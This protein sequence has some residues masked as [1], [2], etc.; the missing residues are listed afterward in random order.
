MLEIASRLGPYEVIAPLGAGGMG[1]VYRARDTRLGREVAIKVLPAPFAND[2]ERRARFEREAKAVAAL[3]HPNILAIHDYGSHEGITFAVMELLEGETLR[4]RLD[5]GALS[6]REGAE[7]GAAIA[8]GLAAAHAKGIVH[9]DLKPDNLF[10]TA[11]HRVKILDFGLARIGSP[12]EPQS[13][14]S[15]Y[16]PGETDPGR[17]M[18][19]VGYMSPEQVR[20]QPV[21]ARSDVFAM[22]CVLYE[23]LSGRRPFARETPAETQTAILREEPVP[24]ASTGASVPVEL[25][26]VVC[27]CLEKNVAVRCQAARDLAFALRAVVS[28][29]ASGLAIPAPPAKETS[30]GARKAIDSLAILPLVNAGADASLDYLSDGITESIIQILS[31]LPKLRVMARSTV[32]RYKGR[33]VDAQTVGQTLNVRAVFTGRMF[34]RGSRLII[35]VELVDVADGSQLWGEQYSREITEILALEEAIAQE[36]AGTLRLRLSREQKKQLRKRSTGNSEAYQ[37]Y[38][39]GRYHWNKRNEEGIRR[40]IAHFDLAVGLDSGFSQAHAGLADCYALLPNYASEAPKLALPRAEAAARRALEL[41]DSLAEAHVSLG[42][43]KYSFH[44]DW[45]GAETHFQRGIELN[46]NYATAHHWYAYLLMLLGRFEEALPRLAKA[47]QVDPLSLII[48]ATKAYILYFARRYDEAIDEAQGALA[49]DDNFSPAQYFLALACEQ[50]GM[51]ERALAAFQ[52]SLL[53]SGENAGCDAA[54]LAHGYATAGRTAEAK[55]M[56]DMMVERAK[57]CHVPAFYPALIAAGL[58]DKETALE[59]LAKSYDE[60]DFYLIYLKIDP[61]LDPLRNDSRFVDL[62]KKVGLGS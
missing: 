18:G 24:L 56:L 40:A 29:T 36:I 25:E 12:P 1:E 62:L 20:G 28:G 30:R 16:V 50:K 60:R 3:S 53:L 38:L 6:W 51:H 5:M 10:L 9:R 7:F 42:M 26:R 14:T 35:K 55:K 54:A 27:H 46:P 22:G 2:G 19:T 15:P 45:Q 37:L 57:L 58:G 13:E 8:D 11:D 32:F 34:L 48:N 4:S 49:L 47:Q 41:D 52:K 44:W 33:D 23:M 61:R 31:R 39:K 59:W 43:V 17:I 21:D